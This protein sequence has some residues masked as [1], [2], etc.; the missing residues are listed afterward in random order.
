MTGCVAAPGPGVVMIFGLLAPGAMVACADDGGPRLL[1]AM[2]AAARRDATVMLTG[3]RLCGG[4]D[5]TTAAGE[6]QIG[7]EPPMVRALV[8]SYADTTAEIVI[9]SV[10]PIGK[11]QLIVTVDE[12]SSNALDF[13]VLP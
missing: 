1:T 10:T 4:G 3:Q 13:E 12:R 7:I 9:P 5:C 11:T 8:V 6:V 2:P